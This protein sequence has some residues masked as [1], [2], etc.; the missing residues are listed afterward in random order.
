MKSGVMSEKCWDKV[1]GATDWCWEN[2]VV[3]EERCFVG[4]R[5]EGCKITVGKVVLC[6]KRG[7]LLEKHWGMVR[8]VSEGSWKGSV[9]VGGEVFC[10][11]MVRGV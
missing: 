1:G 2:S 10:W 4:V 3:L 5:F 9:K 8:R 7:I 6:R 11:S